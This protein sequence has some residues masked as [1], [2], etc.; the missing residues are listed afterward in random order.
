MPHLVTNRK[1]HYDLFGAD[2]EYVNAVLYLLGGIIFLIGSVMFFPDFD[3]LEEAGAWLFVVGSIL[4]TIVTWHDLFESRIRI[5]KDWK[6]WRKKE[7]HH[8]ATFDEKVHWAENEKWQWLEWITA[9]IYTAASIMFVIGSIYFLPKPLKAAPYAGSWLFVWG[10]F[11]YM[12]AGIINVV[13]TYIVPD[14]MLVQLLAATAVQF[15]IGSVLFIVGSIIFLIPFV[16][17][18]DKY[19]TGTMAGWIFVTGSIFFTTGGIV[20]GIRIFYA[21]EHHDNKDQEALKY[22]PAMLPP[23]LG[24]PGFDGAALP[25]TSPYMSPY[26]GPLPM[27]TPAM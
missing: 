7:K 25:Q 17:D 24:T 9:F 23:Y 5:Q 6:E 4:Y 11:L 10:S 12:V 2:W 21:K 22:A 20:N 14:R 19:R 18:N 8:H 16:E 1:R 13:Q 3:Y 26:Y 15:I 27:G